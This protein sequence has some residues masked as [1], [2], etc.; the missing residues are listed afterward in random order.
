MNVFDQIQY[1]GIIHDLFEK[2]ADIDGVFATSDIIAAFVIKA[3]HK[4]K[5][6]HSR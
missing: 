4:L 1:E 2:N 6:K 3:C 5:K